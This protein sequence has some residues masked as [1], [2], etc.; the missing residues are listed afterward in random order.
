MEMS[1]IAKKVEARATLDRLVV[2]ERQL[3]QLQQIADMATHRRKPSSPRKRP[4]L[5]GGIT[6]LFSGPSGTQDRT[7][8]LEAK[9]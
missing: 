6:A 3:Q 1:Q 4:D 9:D 7:A 5:R 2:T 8:N